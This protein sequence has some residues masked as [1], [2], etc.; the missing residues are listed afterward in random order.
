MSTHA[1]PQ[2]SDQL[3]A[4]LD[5]WAELTALCI[6][7]RKALLAG[8]GTEGDIERRVWTG[9]RENKERAWTNSPS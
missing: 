7:L 5:R 3:A 2:G 9:L 1:A 6:E 8:T 4:N